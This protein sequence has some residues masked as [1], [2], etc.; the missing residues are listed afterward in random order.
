MIFR[1]ILA[2][3]L[4][5]FAPSFAKQSS[6]MTF[7]TLMGKT[8][9]AKHKPPH[10]P[11]KDRSLFK[12]LSQSYTENMKSL[13]EAPLNHI[14]HQMH[15]IWI[16]PK[17]FPQESVANVQ[18]FRD[19]HPDWT[20]NF[21]TDS[22]DRQAPIPDMVLR[23]VSE[24]Y[25]QEIMDLYTTSTNY[26]EKADL[27]RCVF[28]YKEGGLYFDHDASC[29]Q[30]F[31]GLADHF[32]FV[33]ACE[34]IQYHAGMDSFIAPAIGLF[35]SRPG[36]PI[37]QRFIDLAHRRWNTVPTY[38]KGQEWRSVIYRTFDSFALATKDKCNTEGNR[39]L[40]LPTAYFYPNLAFK[41]RFLKKLARGG[42]VYSI[43]GKAGSWRAKKK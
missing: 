16:G 8:S 37:L 11:R 15:V 9:Q 18:S 38:P 36:H 20:M 40:I 19:H 24:E 34:R 12:R 33:V 28:M 10:L 43:H 35:L 2:A 27:L 13:N 30:S 21:W 3:L 1:S 26:A 22:V 32:D 14:P 17:P 42:Y 29:L 7:D 39:D 25:F 41:P 23:L 6:P 5:V 31:N 4:V